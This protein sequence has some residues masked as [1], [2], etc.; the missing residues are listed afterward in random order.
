M[1]LQEQLELSDENYSLLFAVRR[2]VRYHD[3]RR[4]FYE[5]M[6]HVTSLM[7]VLMAGSILFDLGKHG[8]SAWWLLFLSAL[9]ALLAA[10]DM[11]LGYSRRATVHAGLRGRFSDL[12]IRML[13]GESDGEEWQEYQK[14]RLLIEKDEPAI[15]KILDLLCHNELLLAEGFK[16]DKDSAPFAKITRWQ[17]LTSQLCHWDNWQAS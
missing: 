4:M 7:T 6:H 16:P 12:E 11:V 5:Q 10:S 1:K 8:D 9:A 3:R 15:Y 14:T 13:S 2:S 17:K